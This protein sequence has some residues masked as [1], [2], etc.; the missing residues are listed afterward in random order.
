[1]AREYKQTAQV[2]HIYAEIRRYL[3]AMETTGKKPNTIFV[4]KKDYKALLADQNK[5]IK[6]MYSNRSP[7]TR[8]PD[9]DDIPIDIYH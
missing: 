2:K 7:V 8:V 1:M 4:T 3:K 5:L 6:S 9:Y